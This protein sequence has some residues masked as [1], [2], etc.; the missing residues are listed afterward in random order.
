[1]LKCLFLVIYRIQPSR[2]SESRI[3]VAHRD[4]ICDWRNDRRAGKLARADS[5][6]E[7]RLQAA[8]E[9]MEST[10]EDLQARL[11]GRVAQRDLQALSEFYDQTA[12]PLFSVALRILGDHGE[13]EEVI[14]DVF[15][16]IWD[17]A[18]TF[19]TLLGSA[20]HWALSI[21]RHRAIDRL[22]SRQRRTRLV[23]QLLESGAADP[24]ESA[25]PDAE[26]LGGEAATEVRSALSGLPRDQRQAIELAFFAGLTHPEIAEALREPLGTIKARIRR[27]LLRLREALEAEA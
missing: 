16:Q 14:Q 10:A 18:P 7:P 4:P 12:T 25:M 2:R 8:I 5:L 22:R 19:D 1:L 17:K 6:R 9:S 20:F 3:D 26:V 23:E 15:V 24:D 13:A 11:L 21:T 27:G